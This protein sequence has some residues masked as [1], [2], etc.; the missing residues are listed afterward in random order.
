MLRFFAKSLV[1]PLKQTAHST[2]V[3]LASTLIATGVYKLG[4]EVPALA[5]NSIRMFK[6]GIDRLDVPISNSDDPFNFSA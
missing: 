1:P 4:A 5:D 6:K 3:V 2:A